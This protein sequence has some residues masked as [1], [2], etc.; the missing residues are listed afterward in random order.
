MGQKFILKEI[1]KLIGISKREQ[2]NGDSYS[3]VEEQRKDKQ[4]INTVGYYCSA[5]KSFFM[6]F[7]SF[8]QSSKG[9]ENNRLAQWC[10]NKCKLTSKSGFTYCA[11]FCKVIN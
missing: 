3:S 2:I 10:Y 1:N 11:T 7:Y 5:L 4:V 8:L 6:H 9:H